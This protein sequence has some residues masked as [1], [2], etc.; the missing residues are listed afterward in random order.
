MNK[1]TLIL[2]SLVLGALSTQAFSAE[3][4]KNP[5]TKKIKPKVENTQPR[6]PTPKTDPNKIRKEI[7]MKQSKKLGSVNGIEI[8]FHEKQ[9]KYI[10]NDTNITEK[11][12]K[13]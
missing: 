2:L 3:K 13:K 12:E 8:F 10:F 4:R 6:L 5:F 9:D 7:E 1:A 11:E